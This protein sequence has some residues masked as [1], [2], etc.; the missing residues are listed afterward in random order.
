MGV[1]DVECFDE[2]QARPACRSIVHTIR[3]Q[4]AAI[5]DDHKRT[6][7]HGKSLA[8]RARAH[9]CY[10]YKYN[11]WPL[12]QRACSKLAYSANEKRTDADVLATTSRAFFLG[13]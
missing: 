7:C 3:L 6:R 10:L 5:S 12:Q 9:V 4:A 13:S 11:R 2:L 1:S 8:A